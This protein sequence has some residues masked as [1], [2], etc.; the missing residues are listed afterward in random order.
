M[1]SAA[2]PVASI[3]GPPGRDS[4]NMNPEGLVGETQSATVPNQQEKSKAFVGKIRQ[5]HSE[6]DD[7][8][9]QFPAFSKYARQA[10]DAITEGLTQVLS[11]M[12]NSSAGSQPP[13]IG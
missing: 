2:G 12:Q 11:E 5:F 7:F 1:A 13:I 8:A 3:G 9:R 10:K 6:L 4:M